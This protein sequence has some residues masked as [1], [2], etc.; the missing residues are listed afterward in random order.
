MD[1]V[2]F[3]ISRIVDILLMLW[4]IKYSRKGR[5]ALGITVGLAV[6]SACGLSYCLVFS[7]VCYPSV[8]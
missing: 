2:V 5:V 3:A 1:A 6:L 8:F 4:Y 7:V